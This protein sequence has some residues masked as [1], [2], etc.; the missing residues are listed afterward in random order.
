M[1]VSISKGS[2][3][4]MVL[5][6]TTLKVVRF[7]DGGLRG[8]MWGAHSKGVCGGHILTVIAVTSLVVIPDSLEFCHAMSFRGLG[9]TGVPKP[10]S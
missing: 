6:V 10:H 7:W 9:P 2:Q 3:T 8:R 4:I 1:V 5:I